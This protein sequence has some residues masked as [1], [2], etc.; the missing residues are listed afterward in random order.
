M[1]PKSD[2]ILA[3]TTS[4]SKP[5][6]LGRAPITTK[7]KLQAYAYKQ[8]QQQAK[9]RSPPPD[10]DEP[11]RKKPKPKAI[12][13]PGEAFQE[14]KEKPKSKPKA[15]KPITTKEKIAALKVEKVVMKSLEKKQR[16]EK[17]KAAKAET[18]R[19]KVE[20]SKEEKKGK[21]KETSRVLSTYE[22]MGRIAKP[23]AIKFEDAKTKG[24]LFRPTARAIHERR[25]QETAKARAKIAVQVPVVVKPMEK[26][27]EEEQAFPIMDLPEEVRKRVWELAVVHHPFCVWPGQPK[28]K[29]QPDLA[30]SGRETRVEVLAVFYGRNVFGIDITPPQKPEKQI[31]QVKVKKTEVAEGS[32]AGEKGDEGAAGKQ[33]VTANPV[34]TPEKPHK[35]PARAKKAAVIDSIAEIKPWA[36]ALEF[37]GHLSQ[38][39]H[40]VFDCAPEI[41]IPPS[42]VPK[43]DQ[44]KSVVVCLHIWREA[45]DG[46]SQAS[47]R[48]NV[49]VHREACCVLPG[50]SEYQ[51]CVVQNSPAWLNGMVNCLL[52]A[53]EKRGFGADMVEGVAKMLRKRSLELLESRCEQAA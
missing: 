35:T 47:W 23:T 48:A 43:V 52:Q 8:A 53:V 2:L 36:K 12:A 31:K 27:K 33:G 42:R 3:G 25:V 51:R 19:T 18:A 50:Q 20:E 45:G 15:S 26:K 30:M 10:L 11:E 44:S 41:I 24:V 34:P 16:A 32:V 14:P 38:I 13:P 5:K 21:G 6:P 1:A 46:T 17:K 9:L 40:W 49:E 28:G 37:G 4:F 7:E 22:L 29:E 39:R